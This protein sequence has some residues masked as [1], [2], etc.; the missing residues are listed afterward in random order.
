MLAVNIRDLLCLIPPRRRGEKI[1]QFFLFFGGFLILTLV[2]VVLNTGHPFS[3]AN[4][5]ALQCYDS[6]CGAPNFDEG[7]ND[8]NE[9]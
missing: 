2:F 9:L 5:F 3:F 6:N 1:T 8:I 4:P 7:K